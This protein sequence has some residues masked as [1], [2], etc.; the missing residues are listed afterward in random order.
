MSRLW[1]SELLR[2]QLG[3]WHCTATVLRRRGLRWLP[4]LSAR[5]EGQGREALEAALAGLALGQTGAEPTLPGSARIELDDEVVHYALLPVS[6]RWHA[7]QDRAREQFGEI[8]GHT[9]WHLGHTLAPGG[10]HWL[11]MA[12][13]M[14]VIDP[15]TA[16][17]RERGIATEAIVGSLCLDLDQAQPRL[18][19]LPSLTWLAV[20]RDH[21]VQ[22]LQFGAGRQHLIGLG[23]HRLDWR[24]ADALVSRLAALCQGEACVLLPAL[25]GSEAS[26]SARTA[27]IAPARQRQWLLLDPAPADTLADPSNLEG[28]RS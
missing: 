21:G 23:W 19:A 25:S 20:V 24:D 22:L 12:A 17:L 5:A 18:A 14:S 6:G 8:L 1:K 27:L 13:E 16:L 7:V 9:G 26:E 15:V 3:S 28:A 11:V 2:V 4:G 10:S